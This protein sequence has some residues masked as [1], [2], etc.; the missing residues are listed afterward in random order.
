[1]HVRNLTRSA[2]FSALICLCA[3]LSLPVFGIPVTLQSFAIALCL[4]TLGGKWGSI[5]ILV[6]LCIGAVG[7]PVFSG[8]GSGFGAL[9]G[10]TGGYLWGFLAGALVYWAV[11]AVAPQQKL[12]GI[13]LMQAVCYGSGILWFSFRFFSHGSF[14][15][16]LASTVLPFLL[17][18]AVKL[19]LAWFLAK[20]LTRN[21][22]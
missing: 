6:Y 20:R 11:T 15:D 10:P 16:L 21:I 4:L 7:V 12:L 17:P 5:S 2:V 22:P 14:A 3:W 18:D 9:T 1:M 8:F 19:G 13:L